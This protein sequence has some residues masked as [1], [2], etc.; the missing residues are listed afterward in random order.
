MALT[1]LMGNEMEPFRA[2]NTKGLNAAQ[3]SMMNIVYSRLCS[4]YPKIDRKNIVVA[5]SNEWSK[6][7]DENKL[8]QDAARSLNAS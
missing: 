3:L 6:D 7:K 4:W 2:D 1:N 5:V 8:Y